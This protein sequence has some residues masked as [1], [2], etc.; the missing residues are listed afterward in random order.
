MTGLSLSSE[1]P[2]VFSCKREGKPPCASLDCGSPSLGESLPVLT[3]KECFHQGKLTLVYFDRLLAA[4]VSAQASLLRSV[5]PYQ[6]LESLSVTGLGAIKRHWLGAR[7]GDEFG[8]VD[9]FQP[10]FPTASLCPGP[11]TSP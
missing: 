2:F 1:G 3:E 4:S 11:V 6:V 5:S 8:S 7:R 10:D 9:V